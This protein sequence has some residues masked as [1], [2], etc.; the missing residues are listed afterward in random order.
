MK[1]APHCHK[2]PGFQVSGKRYEGKEADNLE[3]G[4]YEAAVNQEK[5]DD[6]RSHRELVGGTLPQQMGTGGDQEEVSV[7]ALNVRTRHVGS[8]EQGGTETF[9]CLHVEMSFIYTDATWT[10]ST[11]N[12]LLSLTPHS[13]SH[14]TSSGSQNTPD[15]FE[16]VFGFRMNHSVN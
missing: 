6:R 11:F 3:G 4:E 15:S 2:L 14:L 5:E 10:T 8:K 13:S 16:D 9:S 1:Y 12:L 7:A